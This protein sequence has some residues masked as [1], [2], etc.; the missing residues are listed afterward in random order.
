MK[1]KLTVFTLLLCFIGWAQDKSSTSDELEKTYSE[2]IN[3]P[4]E[5]IFVHLNKGLYVKG[6]ALAFNAYVFEKQTKQLSESTTTL[7]CEILDNDQNRVGVKMLKVV[8]GT[9]SNQ[10]DISEEYKPG[11]YTFKAY[12]NWLRNFP[13]NNHF[14]ANFTV[15]DREEL[16]NNYEYNEVDIY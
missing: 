3:I 1:N 12:T 11:T 6:E 14:E 8:N 4:R 2:Y 10:F 5:V 15:V 13:E 9:V 16:N 7:Y